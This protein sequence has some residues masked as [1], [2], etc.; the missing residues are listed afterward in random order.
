MSS[1]VSPSPSLSQ[2]PHSG[3][4]GLPASGAAR[5]EKKDSV[6]GRFPG[7][8][9][10]RLKRTLA[11]PL[12]ETIGAPAENSERTRRRPRKTNRA[13]V[14]LGMVT[15]DHDGD[16]NDLDVDMAWPGQSRGIFFFLFFGG[17]GRAPRP[18]F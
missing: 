2:S 16:E 13:V 14:G 8:H 6:Q 5:D 12:A 10:N 9:S 7:G 4:V 1:N 17:Q 15:L 11:A 18:R 3:P